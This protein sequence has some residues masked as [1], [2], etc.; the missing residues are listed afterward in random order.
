[1]KNFSFKLL[2]VLFA[3]LLIA[4]CQ[5]L[6]V[7]NPNNPDTASAL[8]SPED[9][10]ALVGSQ[11][12]QW[13][14][15]TQKNYPGMTLAVMS[16]V[17][18]SSW[19]NFGMFVLGA[20]PREAFINDASYA[21]R[22]MSSTPWSNMYTAISAANDGLIAL[23][24]AELDIAG[25]LGADRAARMA[26]F[27]YFIQGI[28]YGYLANHFDRAFLVD[29]TT[30][31]EQ[32]A[33]GNIQLDLSDYNE[34]LAF[35]IDKLDKAI[36]ASG[37]SF[38][39]P[40]GWIP[41]NP[42][43]N[44]ELAHLARAYKARFIVSNARTPAERDA[45]DWN[46]VGTI[47]NQVLSANPSFFNNEHNAF[48]VQAD[49]VFWWSR[50]HSLMQDATWHRPFYYLLGRYD[51]SGGFQNWLSIP[52]NNVDSDR[53]E[54]IVDSADRR[55]TQKDGDTVV[56]GTDF[57]I[58]SAGNFPAERGLWRRSRHHHTRNR[59][60]YLNGFVGPMQHMRITELKMYRAE[61]LLRATP[62]TVSSEVVNL[63]NETRVNRGNLP[64]ITTSTSWDAAFNAM[65]YEFHIETYATAAGLEFY[66][67]RGWGNYKGENYGA[68]F[69][70]TPLM[71]P[72][73]AAELE[74]LQM[75]IYTFGGSAGGGAALFGSD[76]PSSAVR[77]ALE[78]GNK[79]NVTLE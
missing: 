76:S 59:E 26:A 5:D 7:K 43:T 47:S 48:T 3:V 46:A 19:G 13:W 50:P 37:T 1:M 63:V 4:G 28:S 2:T 23:E 58:A 77:T 18:T 39:L 34:V 54:F 8:A 42:L 65:R 64:A 24:N 40:S 14:N 15:G 32:V 79:L 31:L 72:I 45:I 17:S 70:G 62:G 29:E 27:S 67:V 16:G 66:N 36:A 69:S 44:T 12:Q 20:V 75:E 61:A 53:R 30:D 73:P 49:G 68:L 55:V 6:D 74:L 11:Y 56:N 41:G 51:Q 52:V 71:F 9:V 35:A 21:D 25:N 57:F 22:F 33:L 78:A 60:M 10:E 38:T